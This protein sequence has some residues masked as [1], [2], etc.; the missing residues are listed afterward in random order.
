MAAL[1]L[2][3]GCGFEARAK[4]DVIVD[5][6][7]GD[8][9]IDARPFD[10]GQCPTTY[11]AIGNLSSRYRVGTTNRAFRAAHLE[12]KADRDGITHVVVLDSTAEGTA[13]RSR[14]GGSEYWTGAVQQ[15]NQATAKLN[16]FSILG[17]GVAMVWASGEPN[18]SDETE[19]NLQNVAKFG[20]SGLDD[21]QHTDSHVVVCECDGKPVDA[22][23]ES[24]IQ[25]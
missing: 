23:V 21:D 16:W 1:A 6:P 2:V 15:P 24:Y 11:A 22:T 18:E 19:H 4:G 3:A 25:Q 13:I 9:A 14:V 20:T 7:G 5:A 10:I 8:A 17:G 12:C